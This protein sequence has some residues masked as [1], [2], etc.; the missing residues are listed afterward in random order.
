MDSSADPGLVAELAGRAEALLAGDDAERARRYPGPVAGRQPVHTAYVPADR[1]SA[2]T[3]RQW[4]EAGPGAQVRA[5]V[6][7]C[8]VLE[9]R[10]DLAAGQ[11]RFEIQVETPQAV[12]GPDGTALVAPMI[13]AAAGRCAG[14]HYGTYDYSASLG[15]SAA[16][17]S[18]A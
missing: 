6:E 2:D 14:L 11:L 18:L 7:C 5:M 15:I 10:L 17:Q 4:G 9:S 13:T 8:A 3:P 12:L 1:F 16:F